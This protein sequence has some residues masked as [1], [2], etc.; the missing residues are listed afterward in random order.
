MHSSST[1]TQNTF[2]AP[3]EFRAL[4]VSSFPLH[5]IFLQSVPCLIVGNVRRLSDQYNVL[6]SCFSADFTTFT[7]S[8]SCLPVSFEHFEQTVM[9]RGISLLHL[10][11]ESLVQHV[12]SFFIRTVLPT[13]SRQ[14]I[15]TEIHI[16]PEQ[17]FLSGSSF[18]WLS[19][20]LH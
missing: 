19:L 17:P 16:P 2:L 14:T 3:L 12:P 5:R 4:Q 8:S 15:S 7:P 10:S 11:P 18:H 13:N 1:S 20:F 9:N 6:S